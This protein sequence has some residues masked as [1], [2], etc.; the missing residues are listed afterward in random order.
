MASRKHGE[1]SA[2]LLR[3]GCVSLPVIPPFGLTILFA[4]GL[5]PRFVVHLQEAYGAKVYYNTMVNFARG[6]GHDEATTARP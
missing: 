2:P 6:L 3:C 1:E 4:G 5:G